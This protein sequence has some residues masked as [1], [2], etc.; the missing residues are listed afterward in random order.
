M[1][2][3][4]TLHQRIVDNQDPQKAIHNTR[5]AHEKQHTRIRKRVSRIIEQEHSYFM[6]FTLSNDYLDLKHSTHIKK[7]TETLASGSVID[8]LLNNDYGDKNNRLHYH[9]VA[10]FNCQLDYTMIQKIYQYGALDIK[11]VY[12]KDTKSI[13]EY[14]Q[15]LKNHAI[16]KTTAYITYK[17]LPKYPLNHQFKEFL[18]ETRS[19]DTNSRETQ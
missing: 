15:K 13:S 3:L 6:T 4:K 1:R 17:R 11:K 5:K 10:C 14:I 19:T 7:I 18:Y 9:A 8:Y 2:K 16:K 12:K